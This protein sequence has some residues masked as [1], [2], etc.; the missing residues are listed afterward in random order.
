MILLQFLS[1]L[2]YLLHLSICARASALTT[3]IAANER[4]CFYADVD[5]AGEKIG[6][7]HTLDSI[8]L[9]TSSFLL[10]STLQCVIAEHLFFFFFQTLVAGPI[11]RLVR[12][13]F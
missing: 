7:S 2:L 12:H 4:L 8:L 5:K 3:A 9:F 13:R 11:R 6:V 1:A 10:S